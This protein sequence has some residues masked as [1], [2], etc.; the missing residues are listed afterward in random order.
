M[1][2]VPFTI[3]GERVR[4][5]VRTMRDGSRVGVV[6]E[7]LQASPHRVEPRCPHFGTARADLKVSPYQAVV[8]VVNVGADLQ[9]GPYKRGGCGGCSWQHIAYAEQ[10]RLKSDLVTRLV[11]EAVPRAP[12]ARPTL[13]GTPIESP[14]GYRQKV[15]F[16]FGPGG[17]RLVM[18]H[19]ARGTRRVIAVTTC[20]VHDERGNTRAFS[21]R[22]AFARSNVIPL[23]GLAVRVA[24]NT[25]ETMTTLV[26]SGAADRRIRSASRSVT[27]HDDARSS[28]HV[29][30]HPR[31][32]AYIFGRET[33]R[34]SGPDRLREEVAGTAFLISPTSFFQT[35]VRAAGLLVRLVTEAIPRPSRV[36]D[37]YAGAGLF[38]LPL[39]RAGHH[40]VAVEENRGSVA[41][42]EASR[43]LN[44]IGEEQ[45]RFI[46]RRVEEAF[47][48]EVRL[49]ADTTTAPFDVVVMDPPRAGCTA[50]VLAGVFGGRQPPL[51]VYVSCNPEALARDLREIVRLGYTIESLQPVDMFPHTAHIETV[52]VLNNAA[53]R[54]EG[55]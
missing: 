24:A 39:A 5:S 30:V 18:G 8:N 52:A 22:D 14:W 11:R 53:G 54:V 41:D 36:L 48:H 32:D 23:K 47:R 20:P 9:V 15:H 40:V 16:V 35:N 26:L 27:K 51:V 55:A 17:S 19:Y 10:L 12:Q 31:G 33:R 6:E 49:K 45:C 7:L 38:A 46:G 21:V 29:N 25:R 50:R 2:T 4:V 43:R 42:G 44:R 1:I 34:I 13:A 3:P 37:L 28:L